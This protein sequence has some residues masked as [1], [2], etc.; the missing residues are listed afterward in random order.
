MRK[1]ISL[2]TAILIGALLSGCSLSFSGPTKTGEPTLTDGQVQTQIS[3]LLTAQ[4]TPT[5]E[6]AAQNSATPALPTVEPTVEPTQPAEATAYPPADSS[7]AQPTDTQ[8]APEATSA[9]QGEAQAGGGGPTPTPPP[10]LTPT[11]GSQGPTATISPDDPRNRLGG[12]TSTD[13]MNDATSWVWPTGD[14]EF[15][16]V[17]YSNGGLIFTSL[18]EKTGWRLANPT[19]QP[20]ANLYLEA[21]IRTGTC[22]S[23]DQYG[24]IVRVPV[25][26]DADQGYLFGFTCDGT[27]SFR[28]WDGKVGENGKMTRL[29]DWKA[30]KAINTGSGQTNRMGLMMVGS[31]MLL[32][33]N[34]TFLGEVNTSTYASGYFG[35][36]VGGLQ[37]S[38]FTITV[39]EMA[40]WTN[41]KP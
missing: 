19:G 5:A 41:P 34:G 8:A 2:L 9:V 40:Y 13:G 20:L 36:F 27:Y 12:A 21:T 31:R 1:S 23:N 33:A 28:S 39:D 35:L 17:K 16:A 14:N 18:K 4:P 32:Y 10:T 3:T 26:K 15:T 11:T 38:G 7:S 6:P 22:K 24:L 29:I 25:L 30:S 37:T